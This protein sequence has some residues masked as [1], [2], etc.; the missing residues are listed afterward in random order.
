[1]EWLVPA[2]AC[3]ADRRRRSAVDRPLPMNRSVAGSRLRAT[4]RLPASL[5]V[6]EQDRIARDRL[7]WRQPK[8]PGDVIRFRTNRSRGLAGSI[9]AVDKTRPNLFTPQLYSCRA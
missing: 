9:S 2:A 6:R 1:M 7:A 3:P 8:F 5:M 4:G